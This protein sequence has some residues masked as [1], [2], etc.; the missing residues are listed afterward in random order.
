MQKKSIV[1]LIFL[2]FSIF[3]Q[4]V[5]SEVPEE[6]KIKRELNFEFEKKP[7]VIKL[8][9]QIAISFTTKGFCDVTVAIENSKGDIVRHLASGVLG[10]KAPKPFKANSK[11]QTLI[12]D[13]KNDRGRYVNN[14]NE[15]TVRVSLGLKPQYEKSLYWEPKRRLGRGGAGTRCTED[16]IPVATPEGVYLYDGNGVD[17][18]KFFDH[19]GNYVRMIYPFPANQLNNIKGLDWRE[20]PH[21]YKRPY[22]QGTNLNTLLTSGISGHKAGWQAAVYTM[23]VN[24]SKTKNKPGRISLAKVSLNR[25]STV[26]GVISSSSGNSLSLEGPKV[27]LNLFPKKPWDGN[28]HKDTRI[29]PYS[30]AFSPDG[31][32]LYLAG[33]NSLQQN[34]HHGKSWVNRVMVMDFE[35]NEEPKKFIGEIVHQNGMNISVTCD[36]KGRVY[37]SDYI[38]QSINVY[39][40]E[41]KLIK[42]IKAYFPTQVCID[43]KSGELYVF[44]WYVGGSIWTRN[45]GLKKYLA[46]EKGKINKLPK[47]SLT[48]LKSF[49][50]PSVVS[51]YDL[52][53]VP[54]NPKRIGFQNW[55]NTSHGTQIR[56]TVDFWSK[57]PTIWLV[58]KSPEQ[59][60]LKTS[61]GLFNFGSG[62]SNAGPILLQ[63]DGKKLKT[64]VQFSKDTAKSV[65]K[66]NNNRGHQRLYVNP[67]TKKLYLTDKDG[68]VGGGTFQN[69][70]EI[71]TKNGDVRKVP[72]PLLSVEDMAFDQ[73]GLVYLRQIDNARRVVRYN[74]ENWREVPW[75]YGSEAKDRRGGDIIS[76]LQVPQFGAGTGW[77]SQGGMW[78]SPKGHLAIW[79]NIKNKDPRANVGRP[80]E[81]RKVVGGEYQAP[82]YQ[83]RSSV[84]CIHV[85]DSRGKLIIED[86]VPGV[87][88]TDGIGID[89]DDDI[90]F[91]AWTPRVYNGKKHFNNISGTLI[92]VKAGK[93]KSFTTGKH[94]PI[95]LSENKFKR[96]HD[97]SGYTLGPTWVDGAKWFYGGVGNS[98]FKVSWGC[99]CWSHSRFTLDYFSRSFAPEVDQFSVAVL[100]KNGNLITRI[101][102]YGNV[103]DGIP[104]DNNKNLNPPNSRS[105]GG[106]EVSLVHGAHVAT[107]SDRYLYIRDIG[108][109][110]IVQVKLNYHKNH[111]T[112]L[113][114]LKEK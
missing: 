77:Q 20:Y 2:G 32:K 44:S 45:P 80:W 66:L 111:K 26:G 62:W 72:I 112:A 49:D 27:W 107:L 65:H 103:D 16:P 113:S 25:I 110:R 43:P 76:S 61:E 70:W 101:G 59:T 10:P 91:M 30:S 24:P 41:A 85:W 5:F 69:L 82:S 19:E 57:I 81:K 114:D 23:A 18:V 104:L 68:E 35:K 105:I 8:K 22:K 99:I 75:D 74:M 14:V 64:I 39:T 98:P 31:K 83:G 100:D 40:P 58:P 11:S 108:N 106:D 94:I 4:N 109:D 15:M 29:F 38:G 71:N 60:L 42:K 84:G 34:V 73:D 97:I 53:H 12:W 46:K 48:I 95:P 17:F 55:G 87:D 96:P 86:A 13:S 3:F 6:L 1:F 21:G 50:D 67:K 89:N 79:A 28:R 63:V 9:D 102:K 52:P 78:I 7:T 90:Y 37:I 56:A 47:P 54:F 36:S 88:M 93:N 51:N 92:K 33:Y